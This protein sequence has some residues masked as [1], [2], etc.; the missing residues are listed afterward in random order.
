[1]KESKSSWAQS[2]PK[3]SR[4]QAIGLLTPGY[5]QLRLKSTR[6]GTLVTRGVRAEQ[7]QQLVSGICP[8]CTSLLAG[9]YNFGNGVDSLPAVA[10]DGFFVPFLGNPPNQ[11]PG[12]GERRF[13]DHLPV[14][15]SLKLGGDKLN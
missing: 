7:V 5:G 12:L 1:M 3:S 10:L 6:F 9:D 2:E 13:S 8:P 14:C 11:V 4:A 15:V